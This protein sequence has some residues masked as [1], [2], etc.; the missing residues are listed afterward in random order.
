MRRRDRADVDAVKALAAGFPYGPA[1]TALLEEAVRLADAAGDVDEGYECRLL[2]QEAATFGG[3]GDLLVA[4]FPWCLGQVDRHPGRFDEHDLLWRYK[5][6]CS[7]VIDLPDV[8]LAQVEGL[9]D[10]MADR[11][12]RYGRG[13]RA[14]LRARY[15]LAMNRGEKAEAGRLF[16]A[17]LAAPRDELS[18]CPACESHAAVEHLLFVGKPAAAV[19]RAAELTAGRRRC[20]SIP[21]ETYPVI[22]VP[23]LKLGRT[24]EAASYYRAGVRAL[25]GGYP[26]PEVIGQYVD[27]LALS[28]NLDRAVALAARHFA[29]AVESPEPNQQFSFALG[30][31]LLADRLAAAGRETVRLRLPEPHPLARPGGAV[32]VGE[33]GRYAAAWAG[34]IADRFDRR[35]GTDAYRREMARHHRLSCHATPVDLG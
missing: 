11:F 23:L 17:F 20:E 35:N 24:G 7:Q 30:L 33:L 1:K 25:R 27:F 15:N 26:N 13:R 29:A 21:R 28:G 34:E 9:L 2:L 18:D 8:P 6:V 12:A 32:P 3:R 5:W 10:D 14:A 22:L 4:H 19:D 16:R 31:R